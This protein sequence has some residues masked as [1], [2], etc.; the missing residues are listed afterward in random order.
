[1]SSR[2]MDDPFQQVSALTTIVTS[3]GGPNINPED[4]RWVMQVDKGREL[5]EWLVS[6]VQD[7]DL[8]DAEGFRASLSQ[9]A[10]EKE[11]H[12]I[13]GA[14]TMLTGPGSLAEVDTTQYIPPSRQRERVILFE[15][16]AYTTENEVYV[17]KNRIQQTE[18]ASKHL[19]HTM[20]KL[21][22]EIQQM[23]CDNEGLHERLSELSIENNSV[24]TTAVSRA[25][26]LLE[27][28]SSSMKREPNSQPEK[29]YLDRILNLRTRYINDYQNITRDIDH[30]KER[31]TS[32]SA[33]EAEANF[34]HAALY[35]VDF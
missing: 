2:V 15:N 16:L 13:L 29:A 32:A 4:I 33:I 7:V 27:E 23:K 3:L 26:D 22:S 28:F 19:A 5:V 20:N 10:L 17:L 21:N 24:I 1:M 9:I 12:D 31:M 8:D 35:E 11:E 6:Q 34:L 30:A 25:S 18:L 14:Q